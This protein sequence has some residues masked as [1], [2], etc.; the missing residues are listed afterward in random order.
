LDYHV[1]DGLAVEDFWPEARAFAQ[2]PLLEAIEDQTG[3][4]L[5]LS[6]D[7]ISAINFNVLQP[8]GRYERHIDGWGMTLVVFCSACEGGELSVDNGGEDVQITPQVG[9]AALINGGEV[10]HEVLPVASGIR[11]TLL[12]SYLV[13]GSNATR[14]PG[15][16]EALYGDG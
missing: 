10:A 9:K 14:L 12:F 1:V 11:V 16:E 15:L 5:E 6:P 7:K 13:R 3:L 8:G 4:E 2:G